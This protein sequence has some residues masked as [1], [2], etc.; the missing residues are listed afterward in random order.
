MKISIEG[1]ST[2]QNEKPPDLSNDEPGGGSVDHASTVEEVLHYENFDLNN[3]VTPVNVQEYEN[4]LKAT[5]YDPVKSKKLIDGFTN[6]FSIG[7]CGKRN[8]K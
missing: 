2:R 6:G 7:Y 4:L 8:V 3:T 5:N 1:M